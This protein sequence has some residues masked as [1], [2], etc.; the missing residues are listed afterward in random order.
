MPYRIIMLLLVLLTASSCSSIKNYTINEKF[1]ESSKS[2]NKML[3]WHEWEKAAAAFAAGP[4]Q[5]EFALRIKAAEKVTVTDVR[6]KT[7]KCNVELGEATVA[8]D[9][10][11]HI[12]PS[13]TVKTIEDNQQWLY[14]EENGQILWRLTTLF[15]E[16]N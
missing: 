7:R 2:Y 1:E 14:T 10:D 4:L 9:I 5:E 12:N 3:R 11:Y 8:I 15:P 16:F 6:L 13:I